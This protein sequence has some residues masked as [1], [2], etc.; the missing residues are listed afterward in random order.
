MKCKEK[1]DY[2]IFRRNKKVEVKVCSNACRDT[3]RTNSDFHKK[4][5][6]DIDITKKMLE[7]PFKD[8]T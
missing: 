1:S 5:N 7:P 2:F 6:R 8:K 4:T 3:M